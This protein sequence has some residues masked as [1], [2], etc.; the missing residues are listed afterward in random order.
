MSTAPTPRAPRPLDRWV[1]GAALTTL[2]FVG[3]LVWAKWWPYTLKIDGLVDSR[4]WDGGALVDVA[5]DA[6]TWWQGA[7]EFTIAYS[8]AVWKALLVGLLIA[9]AIDA[10]LPREWL[11]RVLT[12]RSTTAGAAIAGAASMPSMMCTCCAS[13]V[14]VSLRRTGVPLPSVVAYWLGNPVLNPAVLVF[15]ALVGPWQW[16]ATRLVVGM[17]P[18]LGAAALAARPAPEALGGP[19]LRG[20]RPRAE[21]GAGRALA[22]AVRALPRALHDHPRARVPRRRRPR[23]RGCARLHLRRGPG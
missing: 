22:P 2:L 21:R 12:R 23:R 18:V 1:L 5:R 20:P 15:L 7:W 16:A 8:D 19:H 3:G 6:P 14:A 9:A 10:L 13:P 17:G 4:A 11:R